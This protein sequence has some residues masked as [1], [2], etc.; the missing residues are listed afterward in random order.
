MKPLLII[1]AG[2]TI[3]AAE[4]NFETGSVISFA[5]SA[6]L[7]VF[8]K[9]MPD[10]VSRNIQLSSPFQKD[11]DVM[12]DQDR[13]EIL[14]IC[15]S[16]SC[17]R[18]I[19]TH[20]SGTIIDTGRLLADNLKDKTIVLTGSL[21]YSHDPVYA[22]FNLGNAVTACQLLQPGVYIATSGEVV[23]LNEG[24]EKVK[25]GKITYFIQREKTG[26]SAA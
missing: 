24:V 23:S 16:S 5:K 7:D 3:D 20:G 19:I 12:T 18:I 8:E 9:V 21:P 4:Y 10:A 14:K 11:S 22:A 13:Q 1:A 6:A 17:N 25:S 26:F 2:G 15:R